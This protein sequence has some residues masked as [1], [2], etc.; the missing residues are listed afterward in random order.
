[1]AGDPVATVGPNEYG[2]DSYVILTSTSGAFT[3]AVNDVLRIIIREEGIQFRSTVISTPSVVRYP[4]KA[5][6]RYPRC[7]YRNFQPQY[8]TDFYIPILTSS[9][10]APTIVQRRVIKCTD[11]VINKR[12]TY[13]RSLC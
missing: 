7:Y 6:I 8:V 10:T 2:R 11:R 1:M 12:K 4:N 13:L 5:I 3:E 9:W